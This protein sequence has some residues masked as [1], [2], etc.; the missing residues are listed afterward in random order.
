MEID[1]QNQQLIIFWIDNGLSGTRN[2][3]EQLDHI[4]E[5]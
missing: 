2:L 3:Y 4:A 1:V 5:T